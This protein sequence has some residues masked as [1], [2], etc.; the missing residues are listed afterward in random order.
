MNVGTNHPTGNDEE[1][2]TRD[3][4]KR[5]G[6]RQSHAISNI[7]MRKS[8]FDNYNNKRKAWSNIRPS[9]NNNL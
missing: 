8:I 2:K 4:I 9:G 6:M 5:I 3:I 1:S 7:K